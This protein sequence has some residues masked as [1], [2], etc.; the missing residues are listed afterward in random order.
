M[1]HPWLFK[2]CRYAASIGVLAP[3]VPGWPNRTRHNNL[4]TLI[5]LPSYSPSTRSSVTSS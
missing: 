4:E 3:A 5:S 2:Y 1:L